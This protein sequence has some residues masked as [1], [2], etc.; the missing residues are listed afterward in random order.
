MAFRVAC[1]SFNESDMSLVRA[2]DVSKGIG[3]SVLFEW[4]SKG[5]KCL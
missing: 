2:V 3:S 1:D 5:R 4:A